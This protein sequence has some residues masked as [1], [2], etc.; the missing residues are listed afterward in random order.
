MKIPASHIVRE[1]DIRPARP[2]GTCF[3]CRAALGEAHIIG[4]VIRSR[5]VVIRIELE[6]VVDVPDDWDSERIDFRYD[7]SSYCIDNLLTD[8]GTWADRDEKRCGCSCGVAG[9]FYVR[10]ATPEDHATLPVLADEDPTI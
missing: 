1:G 9:A 6:V 2:D 5:T 7:G 8:L 10:E 4:C 3:Y